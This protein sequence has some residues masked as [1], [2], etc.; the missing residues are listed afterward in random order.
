MS[1]WEIDSNE[2]FEGERG[3]GVGR[4]NGDREIRY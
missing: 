2:L 1:I 3:C 4:W